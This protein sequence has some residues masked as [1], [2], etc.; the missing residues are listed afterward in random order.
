MGKKVILYILSFILSLGIF[1]VLTLVI[2]SNTLLNKQ[3]VLGILEKNDY[4]EKTYANIQEGINNYAMQSGLEQEV[5]ESL[6]TKEKVT[7]DINQVVDF[8]YE[9]K[10]VEIN[11][12]A[13]K[14]ELDNRIDK[15]LEEHQKVPK[16]EEKESIQKLED[17]ISET[18][19][20][21]IVYSSE[22]I[23]KINEPL[24]KIMQS[25]QKVFI[26]SIVCICILLLVIGIVS[27]KEIFRYLGISFM[28][29]GILS[30]LL[31]LLVGNRVHYILI[32]NTAFSECVRCMISSI[33]HMFS[34]VGGT[35]III[36]VM[37]CIFSAFIE[38]KKYKVF[39]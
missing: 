15:V 31:Q 36:G 12:E 21:G 18:Y 13:I 39:H 11:A 2:F 4:Y 35:F 28:T 7:K 3:Y 37:S 8:I 34:I 6:Y 24:Q 5:F 32:L 26:A 30:I 22:I 10:E 25:M 29:S 9:N 27:K 38:V 33:L 20:N 16:Q 1:A 23:E 17:V 14:G 19:V